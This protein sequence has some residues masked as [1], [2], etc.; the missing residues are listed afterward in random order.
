MFYLSKTDHYVPKD[1][2]D[3]VR[4]VNMKGIG[5]STL[6]K[7]LSI[8]SN[9]VPA[10]N[11]NGQPLSSFERQ[12]ALEINTVNAAMNRWEEEDAHLKSLGINSGL[13]GSM[14]SIMWGWHQELMSKIQKDIMKSQEPGR[15]EDHRG[16]REDYMMLNPF[17]QSLPLD[18]MSAITILSAM[19]ATA[20]DTVGG[21]GIRTY[22]IVLA[23][24]EGVYNEYIAAVTRNKKKSQAS[25]SNHTVAERHPGLKHPDSWSA[26]DHV[27]LEWSTTTRIRL[28]ALLFSHLMDVAKTQVSR[29]DPGS[30]QTVHESHPVFFRTYHYIAGKRVGV[31]NIH[32]S[33]TEKLAK[34][35]PT[36]TIS[37]YLPMVCE[38][39]SWTDH[40]EGGFLDHRVAAIRLNPRDTESRQYALTA[41][42]SGD[43]AQVFAGLDV[44]GKTPWRIN[45]FVFD[46][47]LQAWN[48]GAAIAKIPP[49]ELPQSENLEPLATDTP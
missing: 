22:S 48:S 39:K 10:V 25:R 38:P 33:I 29:T 18:R 37:K 27:K 19:K 47:M 36:S 31:V 32:P 46:T 3:E 13:S 42:G 4:G 12:Q 15:A 14:G 49:E 44:L 16:L 41:A 30:G 1:E 20:T 23:V 9:S 45:K 8:F 21:D 6:K 24:G 17:L 28:G 34:A 11:E 43:M 7:S 35:P 26:H 5:L 40:Y 2:I